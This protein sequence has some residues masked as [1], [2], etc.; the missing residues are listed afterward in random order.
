[1]KRKLTYDVVVVGGGA[2]GVS[3][4]IGAAQAG[5]K[6]LLLERSPSL[7]GQATGA[8][9]AFYCGFFTHGT[10]PTQVV[11]G[12]G[13]QLLERLAAMG[14]YDGYLLSP[15]GN[16]I[17]PLDPEALK[18]AMDCLMQASPADF[19]L[20]SQVIAAQCE[21]GR[22]TSLE[23]V[24]DAGRFTVEAKAFVDAS[25]DANLAWLAGA[26]TVFGS[27]G[28][29]LQAA[30]LVMRLD[31]IAPDAVLSPKAIETALQAAKAAGITGITKEKGIMIRRR[32]GD[33][34]FAILPSVQLG[35]LDAQTLTDAEV[36]VR[37]QAQQYLLAFRNHM[38][39]LEHCRLTSTG[40]RLGIRETRRLVGDDTI[41]AQDVLGWRKSPTAV[42]RGGWAPEIHRE[43]NQMAE[44]LGERGDNY[45]GIPLGALHSV[46]RENLWCAGRTVSSDAVA[47]ASVRVMGSSFATGHAA[48]VAAALSLTGG[49]TDAVRAELL[50]QG[51]LI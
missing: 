42:A 49:N 8:N 40:P 46:N 32:L 27:E 15:V 21:G 25:G 22:V 51:A 17:V 10:P 13:Q 35:A 37:A 26:Q 6:T 1:M 12:V 7:G 11:G 9:V 23:C 16:A 45:F 41:T 50:Q 39:G 44:Y 18:Y 34:A 30:T 28:G 24:D 43:L 29:Q 3:A 31:G 33:S 5:A 48:G 19:L 2:S 14:E 38:P 4:A 36:N 47:F 20:Y